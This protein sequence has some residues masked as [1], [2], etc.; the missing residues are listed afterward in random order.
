MLSRFISL[1]L[2][3]CCS[4]LFVACR[5]ESGKK[6]ATGSPA[7]VAQPD[8]QQGVF[9]EQGNEAQAFKYYKETFDELGLNPNNLADQALVDSHDLARAL[10]FLGY[11]TL[12]PADVENSPSVD[13]MQRF[14]NQL[15][16]SAFFAPKITDVSPTLT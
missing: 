2:S 9:V 7:D 4:I 6:I 16:S 8:E 10:Q 12:T 13:L 11:T 3:V 1:L 14:P 5:P 15:L